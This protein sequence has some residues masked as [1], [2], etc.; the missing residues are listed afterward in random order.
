[1]LRF[2]HNSVLNAGLGRLR[3]SISPFYTK[4]LKWQ[5]IIDGGC[6]PIIYIYISK[7]F[8]NIN[9][10]LMSSDDSICHLLHQFVK[11]PITIVYI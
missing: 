6:R 7:V 3:A 9:S 10:A 8:S 1:M 2:K 5:Y 4:L 11:F